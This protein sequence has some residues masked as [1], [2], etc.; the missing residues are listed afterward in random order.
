MNFAEIERLDDL[1][2]VLEAKEEIKFMKQTNG[3]IVCSYIISCDTTWD[4]Q[5]AL[6]ARGITFS[7]SGEVISRPL[8]KFFNV[9]QVPATQADVIDWSKTRRVMLKRDGSMIHTVR[10][11]N[12]QMR[13]SSGARFALKSKKSFSSDV[14]VQAGEWMMV[15][16]DFINWYDFCNRMVDCNFTAIFEWTSPTARI[17]V[18]YPE[19]SLKLLHIRE[20]VSGKYLTKEEIATVA[21]HYKIP[22]VEEDEAIHD[23]IMTDPAAFVKLVDSVEGIEGWV[24][25]FDDGNMVKLK[26]KWYMDRHHAMTFIRRRDIA[27]L[28]L[29]EEIDDLKS[30]LVGEGVDISEINEIESEVV[31]RIAMLEHQ[32]EDLYN[33]VKN[34]DRKTVALTYGKDGENYKYFKLLMQR[35]SGMLPDYKDYFEKNELKEAFDLTQLNLLQTVADLDE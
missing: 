28:A 33:V 24:I 7:P 20:N 22:V 19:P 11:F 17:V 35:Y 29:H 27:I 14:A 8:H 32:V 18:H 34:M 16:P 3:S 5:E 25:Q 2:S 12:D 31:A 23:L 6:E 4:T 30:M 9:N 26:T 13:L 15:Q 10:A 1:Q 21:A